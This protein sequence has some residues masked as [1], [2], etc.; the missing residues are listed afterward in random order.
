MNEDDYVTHAS[1]RIM[2][3]TTSIMRGGAETQVFLLARALASRGYAVHVVSMREPEAYVQELAESNIPLTSLRMRSGVPDPRALLR[4]ARVVRQWQPDVVHGHMVHANLLARLTRLLAPVRVLLTTAHNLTEGARWRELAYRWTDSL[5]TLSTNVCQA[6]VDRFVEVGATPPGR[7]LSMPNGLE[8]EPF[9][10][11]AAARERL[12]N[13]L[14]ADARF[15]WLAV[16]RLEAQK[17]YPTML[18]AAR[19]V[20]AHEPDLMLWIVGTGPDR[21]ALDATRDAF[22]LPADQIVFLGARGDVADLMRAADGYLMSSAWEGL[23]MVLLEASAAHLPIV[24][25][26][27]GGN[28]DIVID[29]A[30]G[31]L[32][33]PADSEALAEAMVKVMRMSREARADLGRAAHANV[34]ANFRLDRVVDRWEGLYGELLARTAS[35]RR[36]RERGSSSR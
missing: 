1:P 36:W 29:G 22:G 3:V 18:A 34:D 35:P 4:L 20:L 17:D 32:T 23:P 16:G 28:S 8:L 10:P 12:R 14:S 5:T 15:V 21:R 31:L 11:D 27:V 30:T 19:D 33:P 7:M 2:F 26:A 25:T 24:A 13:E 6:A 9:R